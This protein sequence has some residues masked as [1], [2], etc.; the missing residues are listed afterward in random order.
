[1]HFNYIQKQQSAEM[2]LAL[3][4]ELTAEDDGS[5][6]S[7]HTEEPRIRRRLIGAHF[8]RITTD[9]LFK[10]G[11]QAATLSRRERGVIHDL[12]RFFCWAGRLVMWYRWTFTITTWLC[13]DCACV[14]VGAGVRFSAHLGCSWRLNK[15]NDGKYNITNVWKRTK[16]FWSTM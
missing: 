8:Q 10:Q 3:A 15:V 9:G 14:E 7:H 13:T 5:R 6:C 16:I 1:M 2:K 11:R 12:T 4:L